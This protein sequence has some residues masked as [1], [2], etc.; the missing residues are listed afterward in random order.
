[1]WRVKR[2]SFSNEAGLGSSA[3]AHAAAKTDEPVREG[4]V[5][6]LE[7]FVDTI[8]VCLMTATVVI[9]TGAWNDPNIPQSA[10][11]ALTT[12]AWS[13]LFMNRVASLSTLPG[14]LFWL[15]SQGRKT[16]RPDAV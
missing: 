5:A 15:Y 6:M 3:I 1:V 8:I 14:M 7:P 11:V 2:A 16:Q 12:A 9:I 13:N 10:G 4:L